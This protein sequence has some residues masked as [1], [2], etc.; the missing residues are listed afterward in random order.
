MLA[1]LL[2]EDASALTASETVILASAEFAMFVIARIYECTLPLHVPILGL[3]ISFSL[4]GCKNLQLLSGP[5]GGGEKSVC[6]LQS[7]GGGR[8]AGREL[9]NNIWS[10]N[11]VLGSRCLTWFLLFQAAS[12]SWKM[13]PR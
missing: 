12:L 1:W 8:A 13:S 9:D 11:P 7:M 5:D 10:R 3:I 6:D 2:L 4:R